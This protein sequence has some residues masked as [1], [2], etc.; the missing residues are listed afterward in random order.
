MKAEPRTSDS[1]FE[2]ATGSPAPK[3]TRN[4]IDTIEGRPQV[5]TK[6]TRT[7]QVELIKGGPQINFEEKEEHNPL[8]ESSYFTEPQPDPPYSPIENLVTT[9]QRHNQ[10]IIHTLT[11]AHVMIHGLPW[12]W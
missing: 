2:S 9:I 1:N 11:M 8:V 6:R 10:P 3:P 4:F 7:E 5:K 12:T